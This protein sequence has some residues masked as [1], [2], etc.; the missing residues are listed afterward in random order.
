MTDFS[1]EMTDFSEMVRRYMGEK[2]VVIC[3]RYQYWG[4]VSEVGKNALILANPVA[5]Q[6]SGSAQAENPDSIDAIN[7]SI[8]IS[9]FAIE[10]IYQPKWCFNKLPNE[11]EK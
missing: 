5:V 9:Y 3:A 11:T 6:N 2:I 7:T 4:I 1:E 8:I 10:L